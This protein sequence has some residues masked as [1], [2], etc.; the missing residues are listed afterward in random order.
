MPFGLVITSLRGV[1]DSEAIF[2]KRI[3]MKRNV[4]FLIILLIGLP[5]WSQ[6]AINSKST[7]AYRN[8]LYSYENKEYGKALKYAEDAILYRKEQITSDYN[9]IQTSLASREVKKAGDDIDS[10]ITV[11][12]SRD[13]YECVD[14]IKY[15]NSKTESGGSI[16]NVLAYIKN[17]E[18]YPEAQKLIGDIYKLEGEYDFAEQYYL[19]ALENASSLD[20]P[21]EKYEIIYLLADLSRLKKDYDSMEIRLLNII[22]KEQN[23]RNMLL[24]RSMKSTVSK[25]NAAAIEK[26]FTMYRAD[27]YFSLKAYLELSSYYQSINELDK[28]FDYSALAVITGFTKVYN[29]LSKRDIDF[30]YTDIASFLDLIQYHPD[31]LK[32][33]NDN[34]VWQSFNLFCTI[35]S[36]KG[37]D[38]FSAE[39]LKILAFHS[40]QKFWQ[41]DAVLRLDKLDGIK[42]PD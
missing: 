6:N 40:P 12:L 8:A 20:V 14:L 25:N 13:E 18:Q 37:Y 39:F 23:E 28:A 36:Q 38:I 31:I 26:Y 32:W 3:N 11:L 16:N 27:G 21:D 4:G 34:G 15:Y 5:L 7:I 1:E 35:C 33:G 29:V 30:E 17:H 24:A 41:Q 9:M 22:G 42:N 2:N 10:I 19:K